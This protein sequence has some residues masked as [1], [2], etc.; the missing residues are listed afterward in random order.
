MPSWFP[1]IDIDNVPVNTFLS[2]TYLDLREHRAEI[3]LQLL[4]LEWPK[5]YCMEYVVAQPGDPLTHCLNM[6]QDSQIYV[7]LVGSHYG[8]VIQD[9]TSGSLSMTEREYEHAKRLKLYRIVLLEHGGNNEDEDNNSVLLEEFKSKIKQE[10][11]VRHFGTP[12]DAALEVVLALT[13]QMNKMNGRMW[14]EVDRPREDFAISV[15]PLAE[16]KTSIAEDFGHN[17]RVYPGMPGYQGCT[18]NTGLRSNGCSGV[19]IPDAW[20][21]EAH[22]QR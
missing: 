18:V 1:N 21:A 3:C 19:A 7:G 2:S 22:P 11:W 17:R 10:C 4:R 14:V 20:G 13:T 5:V 9:E 15:D 8:T 12:T 6:V 16:L